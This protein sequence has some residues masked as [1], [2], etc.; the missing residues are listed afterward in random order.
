MHQRTR[1]RIAVEATGYVL[2]IPGLQY[3][4]LLTAE[5]KLRWLG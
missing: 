4:D 1:N 3:S 5:N 2:E